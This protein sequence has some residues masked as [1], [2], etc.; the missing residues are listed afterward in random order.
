MLRHDENFEPQAQRA[1]HW[2]ILEAACL[3]G[4]LGFAYTHGPLINRLGHLYPTAGFLVVWV[5]GILSYHQDAKSHDQW[6]AILSQSI[7]IICIIAIVVVGFTRGLWPNFL[8]AP[9]L[10]WLQIQ[11]TKRWWVRP[12]QWW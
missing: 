11:F 4:I 1:L 2:K 7:A 9:P 12:G 3:I 5:V 6:W 8:V 10:A